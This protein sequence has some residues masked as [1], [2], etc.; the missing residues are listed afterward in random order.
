MSEPLDRALH[1]AGIR[2]YDAGQDVDERCADALER[3]ALSLER[4]TASAE[5]ATVQ[6]AQASLA[7]NPPPPARGG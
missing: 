7:Q 1:A 5:G 4:L 6:T 3:I 2:P